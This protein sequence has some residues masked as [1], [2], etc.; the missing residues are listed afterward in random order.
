MKRIIQ[1]VDGHIGSGKSYRTREWYAK[2]IANNGGNPVPA[3]FATP[4]NGLSNEHHAEFEKLG[5]PSMV[6]SQD[7]GFRSS[8]EE[9]VR[10]CDA[11]YEG[12]L[13]PNNMIALN[14]VANTENRLLVLDETFPPLDTIRIE[15]EN[16]EDVRELHVIEATNLK[17]KAAPMYEVVPSDRMNNAL[18][19][20]YDTERRFKGYGEH[21][22]KLAAYI[23]NDH[24]RVVI[25]QDSFDKASSG[26]A[27]VKRDKTGNV[28]GESRVWLQFTIFMQPTIVD[29]YK[30][31]LMI[32]A[33]F[34]KTLLS[35]MWSKDVEFQTNEEIQSRLRYQDMRHVADFVELHHAPVKNLSKTFLTRLGT[36]DEERGIQQFLDM[37]ARC[38]GEMF[39]GREHIHCSN[40]RSDDKDFRWLLDGEKGG[41]R[42]ITNPFGWNSLKH[43]N[44][45]AFLA[46]INYDPDTN[47]RLYAFYGITQK[48]AKDALCYQMVY[49]FMGRTMIRDKD[50]IGKP[51]ESGKLLKVVL[52]LPDE[53]AAEAVQEMLGCAASTPLPIDFGEQPKRGRPRVEKSE[54]QKRAEATERKRKSRA[55]RKAEAAVEMTL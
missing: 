38:L 8:T 19:D 36:G 18:K 6:I 15:F 43:C 5:I 34:D 51:D 24:Y 1:K 31:V 47:E 20:P 14:T 35:M 29:A 45:A 53:G 39:P 13:I 12:V 40:K 54:D 17:P 10:Q 33:N 9:Y 7:A 37:I 16:P 48:Q 42:V 26:N 4:T 49:Q 25:D 52:V 27:F 28:I 21:A 41:Q 23:H 30:D 50:N 55:A 32:S 3:T 46:A 44:M 22:K 11:E 2:L